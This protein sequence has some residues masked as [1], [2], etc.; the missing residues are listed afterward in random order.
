[1]K[2]KYQDNRISDFSKL[3]FFIVNSK[4]SLFNELR[5]KQL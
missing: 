4:Q 1:M 5:Q 2:G 3:I